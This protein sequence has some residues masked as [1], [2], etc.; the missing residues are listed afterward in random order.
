MLYVLKYNGLFEG[1]FT[2]SFY[3]EVVC[4][5]NRVALVQFD[6]NKEQLLGRQF[7]LVGT[8]EDE[9]DLKNL[10]QSGDTQIEVRKE[11]I[12]QPKKV[13]L[14]SILPKPEGEQKSWYENLE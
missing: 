9:G 5:K 10:F 2:E 12:E 7:D 13:S 3:D 4:V 14:D 6:H 11:R 8:I 1:D